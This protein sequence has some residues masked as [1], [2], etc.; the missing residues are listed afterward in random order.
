MQHFDDR[1]EELVILVGG[2][3]IKITDHTEIDIASVVKDSSAA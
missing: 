3:H 2:V 1:R